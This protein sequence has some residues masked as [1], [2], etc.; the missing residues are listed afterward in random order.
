MLY[1]SKINLSVSRTENDLNLCDLLNALHELTKNESNEELQ[2]AI[3]FVMIQV[4]EYSSIYFPCIC[5]KPE[6]TIHK[7]L[8]QGCVLL[9][10]IPYVYNNPTYVIHLINTMSAIMRC[11]SAYPHFTQYTLLQKIMN[12]HLTNV[13]VQLTVINFLDIISR[14][15]I[16]YKTIPQTP[17]LDTIIYTMNF[18]IQNPTLQHAACVFLSK[19]MITVSANMDQIIIKLLNCLT[20]TLSIYTHH[21]DIQHAICKIIKN[22]PINYSSP[23][24][25]TKTAEAF[26]KAFPYFLQILFLHEKSESLILLCLDAIICY[27]SILPESITYICDDKKF[28]LKLFCYLLETHFYSYHIIYHILAF[29]EILAKN[30]TIS[31]RILI[32]DDECMYDTDEFEEINECIVLDIEILDQIDEL[33]VLNPFHAS[34]T[35]ES[36][37]YSYESRQEI[38]TQCNLIFPDGTPRLMRSNGSYNSSN[39]IKRTNSEILHKELSLKKEYANKPSTLNISSYLGLLLEYYTSEIKS[40]TN[41]SLFQILSELWTLYYTLTKN[42]DNC[43]D[44]LLSPAKSTIRKLNILSYAIMTITQSPSWVV[45]STARHFIVS[46]AENFPYST[47]VQWNNWESSWRY[48]EMMEGCGLNNLRLNTPTESCVDDFGLLTLFETSGLTNYGLMRNLLYIGENESI[49]MADLVY[50]VKSEY[51]VNAL[52]KLLLFSGVKIH[53]KDTNIFQKVGEQILTLLTMSTYMQ[54]PIQESNVPIIPWSELDIAYI[55]IQKQL[56]DEHTAFVYNT[57]KYLPR[58]VCQIIT[59]FAV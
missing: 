19:L 13:T 57:F 42:A 2:K 33:Y 4:Q 43:A 16:H 39:I 44:F 29:I 38:M 12:V 31:R 56:S 47:E 10:S 1:N 45:K 24:T 6:C 59:K 51:G 35:I 34:I 52:C 40:T 20:Q 27:I 37:G 8:T 36:F 58:D 15:S 50:T 11:H 53:E 30:S 7:M 48:D 23:I 18:H 54:Q 49:S 9:L 3:E 25:E 32:G 17:L 26:M 46:L 14:F 22:I 5:I 55:K 28:G 21:E 41:V